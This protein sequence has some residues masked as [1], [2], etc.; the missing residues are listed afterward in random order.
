MTWLCT[1][2]SGKNKSTEDVNCTALFGKTNYDNSSLMHPIV[3]YEKEPCSKN[4]T[5]REV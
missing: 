4:D 2:Q 1:A 5:N 3:T